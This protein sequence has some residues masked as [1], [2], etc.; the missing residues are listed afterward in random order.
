LSVDET[1]DARGKKIANIVNGVSKTIKLYQSNPLFC[2]ST[3]RTVAA[4]AF[5]EAMQALWAD[6]EKSDNVLFSVTDAATRTKE[7]SI[8]NF[9][10]LP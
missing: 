5:T 9:S 3:N 2:N 7:S 6:S 4:R 10:E 1:T 8:R